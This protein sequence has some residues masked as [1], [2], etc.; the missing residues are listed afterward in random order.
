MQERPR[1][2]VTSNCFYVPTELH[3]A[4]NYAFM[5][6]C[7]HL[8]STCMDALVKDVKL[9]LV[10][11]QRVVCFV[12][13]PNHSKNLWLWSPNLGNCACGCIVCW[14]AQSNPRWNCLSLCFFSLSI[15]SNECVSVLLWSLWELC[16][17]NCLNWYEFG[18][19]TVGSFWNGWSKCV[20]WESFLLLTV[21]WMF[22]SILINYIHK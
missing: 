22:V 21:V 5:W 18:G 7:Q 11:V 17:L 10:R 2:F 8:Q 12:S 19:S 1:V 15:I 3:Y 20:G 4:L 6:R 13:L 9:W 14:T 16:Q